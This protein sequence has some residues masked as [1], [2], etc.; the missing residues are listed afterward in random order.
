MPK[1]KEGQLPKYRLHKQS[2]QAIVTLSGRDFL[3]GKHGSAASK[4]EYRRLTGEWLTSQQIKTPATTTAPDL[5]IAELVLAF[6]HHATIYYRLPS[7]EQSGE[8]DNFRRALKPLR[9]MY[10]RTTAAS[11]GPLA[12]KTVREHMVGQG[13]CRSSVNRQTARLKHLFKWAAENE[14]VPGSVYQALAA[15]AGLRSGRTKAKDA[16]PVQPVPVEAVEAVL[17]YVSRQVQAMIRLQL[18]TGMRP[19]E[20]CAMR[21]CD[22]DTSDE[23]WVYRLPSHKTAHHGHERTVYLGPQ[24]RSLI[25]HFMRPDVQAFLFSPADAEAER[26]ARRHEQRDTPVSCGNVPG[27][28]RRHR[29]ARHPQG[30]YTVTSYRR[31]IARACQSAFEMPVQLREPVTKE[32]CVADTA[33]RKQHRRTARAAWNAANAWHPHQLR[34]TAATRLRKQYGLEAAQVILGHKVLKV[35]ELY[36]EKNREAAKR[37]MAEAG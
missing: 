18:I 36:A 10:G 2:G 31:A 3:L 8:L 23:M 13:W 16:P 29:R 33:E 11:F 34:H 20:V 25:E 14:L 12:L 32:A 17:P 7:G 22:I 19:A 9:Q 35:T 30:F 24:A 28:N 4:Q 6:W 1:L 5:T 26:L 15:V 21:G 37:I 27:S